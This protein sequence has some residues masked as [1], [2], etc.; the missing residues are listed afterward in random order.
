MRIRLATHDDLPA[1]M[2]LVRRVV[3]LMRAA[4]NLQWSETYPDEAVFQRDIDLEQLWLADVGTCTAGLAAITM[5]QEPEY[6]QA[7][8][9]IDE[10]AVVGND[11]VNYR[12]P[13]AASLSL[14]F[15]CE[16]RLKNTFSDR[17]VYTVTRI[18]HADAYI[19]FLPR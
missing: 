17:L 15:G 13:E 16:K 5:D 19:L 8:C 12:K 1:L 18:R 6:A 10:P 11:A 7:G 9:D 14:G 4:G 2:E 3:P